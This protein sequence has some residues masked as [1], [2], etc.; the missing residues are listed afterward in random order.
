MTAYRAERLSRADADWVLLNALRSSGLP[1]VFVPV[2][3]WR[4]GRRPIAIQQGEIKELKRR[5][6]LE[7]VSALKVR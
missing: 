7:T 3:G 2:M 6:Q 5:M 4:Q 1:D